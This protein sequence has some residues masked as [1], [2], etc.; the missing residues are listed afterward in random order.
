ML[1]QRMAMLSGIAVPRITAFSLGSPTKASGCNPIQLSATWT[2]SSPDNVGYKL[3]ILET[4]TEFACS[5]VVGTSVYDSV[6]YQD[7]TSSSVAP[8]LTLQV[9]RRSD[10]AVMSSAVTTSTSGILVGVTCI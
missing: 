1:V 8:T 6:S 9:V 2:I 3:V 4:G 5:S 10:S 7:G